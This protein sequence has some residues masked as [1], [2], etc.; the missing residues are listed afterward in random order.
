MKTKMPT[1]LGFILL[2]CIPCI[3]DA[4]MILNG[5]FEDGGGGLLGW[6]VIDPSSGTFA[7][8]SSAD[9]PSHSGSYFTALG[10]VGTLGSITQSI[11]TNPG[12][13]YQ[14]TFF[15]ASDGEV[16]N[17]FRV[18]WDG[19]IIFDQTDLVEQPYQQITL[20]VQAS[21]TQTNLSFLGRNDNG[22]LSLD[23][24]DLTPTVVPGPTSLIPFSMGMLALGTVVLKR[25]N[26]RN[27]DNPL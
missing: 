18:D 17:E 4:G 3:A 26:N 23:D 11:K 5:S 22:F 16:S 27:Q 10:A 1:V 25:G 14:L 7:A 21:T 9:Y 12:A 19:K 13:S 8:V 15:V 24:I 20:I 6:R 2:V